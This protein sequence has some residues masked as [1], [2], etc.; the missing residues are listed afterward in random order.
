MFADYLRLKLYYALFLLWRLSQ[1]R[2]ER[3]T[4]LG[5]VDSGWKAYEHRELVPGRCGDEQHTQGLW[6]PQCHVRWVWPSR[7]FGWLL[8]SSVRDLDIR[9]RLRAGGAPSC[10]QGRMHACIDGSW[11]LGTFMMV[12]RCL[13]NRDGRRRPDSNP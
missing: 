3:R 9:V 4:E 7:Y 11:S 13:F 1:Q 8:V 5:H 10:G 12:R 6:E 2:L